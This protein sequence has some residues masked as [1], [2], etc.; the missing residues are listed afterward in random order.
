MHIDK[1]HLFYGA[2]V[3]QVAEDDQYTSINQ[4]EEKVG[5]KTKK[6]RCAYVVNKDIGLYLKY[7]TKPRTANWH[8]GK[9]DEYSFQFSSAER[10]K[11]ALLAKRYP[12]CFL[13]LIC[14]ENERIILLSLNDF[15]ELISRRRAAK[16]AKEETYVLVVA[17]FP[18]SRRSAKVYVTPPST[19]NKVLGSPV[20]VAENA[21]PR[22][23]FS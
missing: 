2:A 12:K 15:D 11:I 3:I 17:L 9:A 13:G 20:I 23:I 6:M 14:V 8:E 21:F 10:K 7:W 18:K 19:R 1:D 5:G 16:G 4:F 22:G